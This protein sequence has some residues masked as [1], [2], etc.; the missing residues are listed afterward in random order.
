MQ[1]FSVQISKLHSTWWI[2]LTP[3][4][5]IFPTHPQA[6]EHV[7]LSLKA[8]SFYLYILKLKSNSKMSLKSMYEIFT[9]THV[10]KEWLMLLYLHF[11]LRAHSCICIFYLYKD[12]CNI[13]ILQCP[14]LLSFIISTLEVLILYTPTQTESLSIPFKILANCFK[15]RPFPYKIRLWFSF[16]PSKT[17]TVLVKQVWLCR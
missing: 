6:F 12:I 15:E 10:Q 2:R 13:I 5:L 1:T 9:S 3:S 17:R 11:S 16:P 14:I 8:H 4:F 7:D